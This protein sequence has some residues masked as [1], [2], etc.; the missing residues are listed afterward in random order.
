MSAIFE[1]FCEFPNFLRHLLS[2]K[3]FVIKFPLIK[4]PLINGQNIMNSI[5][6]KNITVFLKQLAT[7]SMNNEIHV[8]LVLILLT[9][10]NDDHTIFFR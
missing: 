6:D 2:L 8:N 9:G 7:N 10:K 1:I 3:S 4:F 5:V